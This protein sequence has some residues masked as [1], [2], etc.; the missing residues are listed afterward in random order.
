KNPK[1]THT[2]D[3]YYG[4]PTVFGARPKFLGTNTFDEKGELIGG[5]SPDGSGWSQNGWWHADKE[6]SSKIIEHLVMRIP[7]HFGLLGIAI[8]SNNTITVIGT[9]VLILADYAQSIYR[10]LR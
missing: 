3:V 9:G 7:I 1:K 2:N 4:N 8:C 5:T 6:P 10:Q